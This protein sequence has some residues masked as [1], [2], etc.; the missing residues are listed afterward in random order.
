MTPAHRVA[1]H[2]AHIPAL[3]FGT[4]QL[5]GDVCIAAVEAAL[6]CGYRHVDTAR[7]YDNEREV[8]Q[9]L[10]SSGVA[11]D[12]IFVTT[13]V[14]YEDIGAGALEKSAEE[15]LG[16]LSLDQVDLLLIHW[17]NAKIPLR[18]SIGALCAARRRGLARHIGVSN[19]PVA[20][21]DE[22]VALAGEPLV[23]NQCEYHP[24]LDQSA[25]IAACRRHGL[26]FTS[27]CPL[28]RGD[29][30]AEPA[31]A[32]IAERLRRTPSQVVLR[33]HVQQEGVVAI[34]RSRSPDHIAENFGIFDFALTTDD[35]GAVS[36]LQRANRRLTN[37][38]WSPRWDV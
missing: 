15:S 7:M 20:L 32:A 34:P 14:W 24:W 9:A 38:G 22:A 1:A 2:G 12:D 3:G 13:K 5:T 4:W 11:R 25:L 6:A 29:V 19:F 21:L 31:I 36:A 37:P 26:A 35:M 23:A 16:R 18:E 33:W 27:Y 17:P 8:G 30:A 10:R 28:G